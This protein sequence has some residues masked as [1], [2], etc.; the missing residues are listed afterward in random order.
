MDALV[1]HFL[2]LDSAF[3][4]GV[5]RLPDELH[6]DLVDVLLQLVQ[7]HEDILVV[8][9]LR[10][11]LQLLKLDVERVMVI[12]EEDLQFLRQ[13]QRPFLEHQVDGLENQ[14][15]DLVLTRDHGDQWRADFV[16]VGPDGLR[17][18]QEVHVS[19]DQPYGGKGDS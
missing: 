17:T 5:D 11:H 18:R 3:S 9:D 16:V 4:H 7:N 1:C 19:D 10:Q 15:A 8:G 13:K 12:D 6:I 2:Q 14:V